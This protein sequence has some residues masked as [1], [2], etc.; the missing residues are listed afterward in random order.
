MVYIIIYG[1]VLFFK[2]RCCTADWDVKGGR[3]ILPAQRK[4]DLWFI[5][6]KPPKIGCPIA[7]SYS[8][9]MPHVNTS[10]ACKAEMMMMK[11]C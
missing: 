1:G 2:A 7:C 3:I 10:L 6:T 8:K 4:G 11:P 9:R 5:I